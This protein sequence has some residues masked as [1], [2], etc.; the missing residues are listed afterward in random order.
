MSSVSIYY[1]TQSDIRGK[2]YHRLNLL[3]ASVLNLERLDILQDS[4]GHPN[5]KLLWVEFATS[6][7]FLLRASQYITGLNRTSSL[8]VIVVCIFYEFSFSFTSVSIYQR[9]Q[10]DIRVKCYCCLKLLQAFVF[11]ME[12]LDILLDTIGHS[13]RK[14]LS[15]EFAQ[16]F[17]FQFQ[18]SQYITGLNR[19]SKL[20]VI[21][22]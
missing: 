19:T 21:V 16:G 8:K 7:R 9:T 22:I 3:K 2:S 5:K 18:V 1:G 20:K 10:S 15:S 6:F 17:C 12:H 11:N 13:S 4:I 14:L